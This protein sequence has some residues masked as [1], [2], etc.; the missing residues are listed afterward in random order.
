M[1]RL[2]VRTTNESVTNEICALMEPQLTN[3]SL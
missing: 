2:T 1:Y 3:N